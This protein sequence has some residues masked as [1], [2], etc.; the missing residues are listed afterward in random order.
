[1]IPEMKTPSV[2]TLLCMLCV[3]SLSLYLCMFLGSNSD[4]TNRHVF[5]IIFGSNTKSLRPLIKDNKTRIQGYTKETHTI[6]FGSNTKSL[7]PQFEDNQVGIQSNTKKRNT[8]KFR[9]NTKSLRLLIEDNKTRI[10]S[11]TKETHT[12]ETT[13]TPK[14]NIVFLNTSR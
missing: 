6:I 1:M 14:N 3:F 5:S 10:Q 12:K 13:C 7:R 9:W 8:T 11:N 2:R 4:Y